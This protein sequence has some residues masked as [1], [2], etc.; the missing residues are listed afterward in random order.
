[1]KASTCISIAALLVHCFLG[2]IQE[3]GAAEKPSWQPEWEKNLQ[4]AKQEG[5]I[6][7]YAAIGPYHPQIFAEFQKDH[8]EVK[9][10][11]IHGSSSRISPRLLAERRAGKYLADIYLGG[12]TS[13]YSFYQNDLFD[14][15]TALFVLPEVTDTS[16][17]WEGKH[18]YIDP[19]RKHIFV[20]EGSVSGFTVTYNTKLASAAEFKS[21]WDLLRPKWKGKIVSLD[22]RDPGFGASELRY[23][24]YH[25]ELGGEFIRRLF[26][27]MEVVL[28]KEHQQALDWVGAGKLALCAFCRDGFAT[29]A[30]SQGLPVDFIN[31]ND[32]K[33]MPR[34]RG[35]ASAITLVNRAPHPAAAKLFVNWFLSRRGQMVY[36]E[37]HGDRDSLRVDIPKDKIPVGQRRI[38]GRK[39]FFVESPEFMD[40]KPA[41]KI[42]DDALAGKARPQ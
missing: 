23:L 11:I 14:P 20:N 22:A 30:K 21:Y 1:M 13:L 35:S 7:I 24:Y 4:A 12:P 26:G 27:D 42:I 34:L 38:A 29:K 5:Q 39:Y 8:P 37:S 41:M 33:E 2:R 25:P 3:S 9:T 10:N 40:V 15:I 19:E 32:L 31:H 16:L 6:T 18:V 28:S 17:W 36:Q